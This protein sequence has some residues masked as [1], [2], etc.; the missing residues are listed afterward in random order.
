MASYKLFYFP[1]RGAGEP[2]RL[3]LAHKEI[4]YE[5]IRI[6]REDWPK[7]KPNMPF[8][9]I[10][11]LEEDGKKLGGST[12]ILRY[13]GE[14]HGLA[15]SNAWDNAHLANISDFIKDFTNELVKVRYEKDETRK[16]EL[17]KRLAEEVFPKYLGKLNE[18]TAATGYLC[19]G[20][21]TW[22][23]LQLYNILDYI[24]KG[25]PEVLSNFSGLTSL[26]KNIEADA[27]MSKWI[28]ER[29]ETEN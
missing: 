27:N 6:A 25:H 29:P 26:R 12:V 10:P 11:V 19:C 14:K 1:I 2:V 21:L 9:V 17:Q 23:D 13:L 18:L 5:D 15:G 4:K 28:K 3:L 8:G 20:R 7:E 24:L 16:Q 22:P